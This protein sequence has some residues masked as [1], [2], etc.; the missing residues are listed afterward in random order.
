[1]NI[2]YSFKLNEREEN[3]ATSPFD[4]SQLNYDK[5]SDQSQPKAKHIAVYSCKDLVFE[6]TPIPTY[7]F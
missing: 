3:K 5:N 7:F 1:M 2:S 4:N 6:P